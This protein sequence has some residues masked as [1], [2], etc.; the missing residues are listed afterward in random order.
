MP[1]PTTVVTPH[2]IITVATQINMHLVG[3]IFHKTLCLKIVTVHTEGG[4]F[5]RVSVGKCWQYPSM[6]THL[7]LLSCVQ[8]AFSFTD[9]IVFNRNS[10]T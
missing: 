4:D 7:T 8:N 5:D 9:C 10:A 6:L 3:M 1:V 2:I